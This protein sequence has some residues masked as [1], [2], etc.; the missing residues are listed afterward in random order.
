MSSKE[1]KKVYAHAITFYEA[2]GTVH[3]YKKEHLEN[4]RALA[5]EGLLGKVFRRKPR[6]YTSKS[7]SLVPKLP[8]KPQN[9]MTPLQ[10][11]IK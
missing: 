2:G 7:Y 10:D 4:W 9:W 3:G 11:L 6:T 1:L 5:C 8:T